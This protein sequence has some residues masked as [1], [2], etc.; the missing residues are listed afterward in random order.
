MTSCRESLPRTNHGYIT[1][2]RRKSNSQWNGG[3]PRPKKI[4]V[5]K[6]AGKVLASILWDQDRILLTDYHPRGQ[7]INAEYSLSLLVQVMDISKEKRRGMFTKA[8]VFCTTMPRLTGLLQPRRKWPT[9]ASSVIFT[10]PILRIWPRRTTNCSLNWK[11][12]W[13]FGIFLPTRGSL[14]SRVPGWTEKRLIFFEWLPNVRA[15]CQ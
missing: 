13:N 10:N 14:L 2:T 15:S 4:R 1:M 11:C 5:H 7:T 12:N 8:V 9:W 3:S 6:S